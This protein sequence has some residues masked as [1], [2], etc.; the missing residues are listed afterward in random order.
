MSS[1]DD[2]VTQLLTAIEIAE[3]DEEEGLLVEAWNEIVRLRKTVAFL[4][5]DYLAFSTEKKS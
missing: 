4:G 3:S 5:G 1:K 2:I